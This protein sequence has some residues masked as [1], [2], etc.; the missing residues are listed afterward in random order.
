MTDEIGASVPANGDD[1]AGHL[2]TEHERKRH[3][4]RDGAIGESEVR[5]ADATTEHF[6]ERESHVR[7]GPSP[8]SPSQWL[9]GGLEHPGRTVDVHEETGTASGARAD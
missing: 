6:D 5:V 7:R 3:S 2:V 8:L 4:R 9:A 1:A